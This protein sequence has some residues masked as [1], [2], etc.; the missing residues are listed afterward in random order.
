MVI[1]LAV[2][3]VTGTGR[4]RTCGSEMY[5]ACSSIINFIKGHRKSG[6]I[7]TMHSRDNK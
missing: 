4:N 1:N 3:N 6:V 7:S 5:C 2:Q